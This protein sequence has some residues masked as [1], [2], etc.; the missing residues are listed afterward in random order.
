MNANGESISIS[1]I[2]VNAMKLQSSTGN[3]SHP[4]GVTFIAPDEPVPEATMVLEGHRYCQALMRAR[5]GEH[6]VLDGEG[7]ACPA[8]AAAFGFRPLPEG[9]KNGR[10]LMGY[11]I[12]KEEETGV[13]M[14][15]GMTTLHPGEIRALYL[16]PLETA[17]IKPDIVVIE[18]RI[19]SL[20][21]IALA[22]LN[23]KGGRRIESSTAVLQAT[24]VDATIFPFKKRRMNLSYGCYGC[25]DAT[26][27]GNDEAVLGFPVEDLSAVASHLEYLAEK[28]I[29]VSRS[30]KAYALLSK[31]NGEADY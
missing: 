25:R 11:G 10:G 14:F 19:E 18:D 24:C 8:A 17:V 7:I 5:R 21:W 28:A 31:K 16:F 13:T 15:R 30:K 20:M 12:T 4:A 29:P 23:A 6:V 26:D 22:F 1:D 9:L 3:K 2:R 27:I